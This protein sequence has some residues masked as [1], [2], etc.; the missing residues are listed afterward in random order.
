VARNPEPGPLLP[1]AKPEEVEVPLERHRPLTEASAWKRMPLPCRG[2]GGQDSRPYTILRD[3]DGLAFALHNDCPGEWHH[4]RGGDRDPNH[5]RTGKHLLDQPCQLCGGMQ[6]EAYRPMKLR[7]GGVVL[8]H[9]R[10]LGEAVRP[11]P[12][13]NGDGKGSFKAQ[14]GAK[15]KAWWL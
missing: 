3:S 12:E 6:A 7:S 8:V 2:C 10:C 14:Q 15:G 4:L 13:P 5:C 9:Y 1:V 11:E